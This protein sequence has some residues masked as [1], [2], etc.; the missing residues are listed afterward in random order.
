MSA[1][2]RIDVR[3][4]TGNQSGAGTDGEVYVGICGREFYLDSAVDDFE[5]GSDRTYTLGVGANINYA[6][7]NDPR[8][9]QLYTE[10]LDRFPTYIRLEPTGSNP[11]WNLE[12]VT[13]TVNRGAGEVV[14]SAVALRDRS[15]LWL[16]QK[17]GK[18]CYLTRVRG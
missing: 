11:E 3:V 17:Y 18:F 5:Q 14:C 13:V 12:E 7:Y 9:P 4:V 8:S 16:G 10:N 15:N 6:G 1:I 2:T